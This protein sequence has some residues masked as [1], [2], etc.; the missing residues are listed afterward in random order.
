MVNSNTSPHL[1]KEALE[2]INFRTN[3]KGE[4]TWVLQVKLLNQLKGEK[5]KANLL[6]LTKGHGFLAH[7]KDLSTVTKLKRIGEV[8][9][10]EFLNKVESLLIKNGN[11]SFIPWIFIYKLCTFFNTNENHEKILDEYLKEKPA[12]KEYKEFLM[13]FKNDNNWNNYSDRS[14]NEKEEAKNVSVMYEELDYSFAPPDSSDYSFEVPSIVESESHEQNEEEELIIVKKKNEKYHFIPETEFNLG[15]KG[16][17]KSSCL[18]FEKEGKV[19][20]IYFPYSFISVN[21]KDAIK[22]AFLFSDPKL[23]GYNKALFTYDKDQ[24]LK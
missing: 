11:N 9:Q 10:P 3:L 22:N 2:K 16:F 7:L 14:R 15:N 13:K 1:I 24:K 6:D 4:T 8:C 17:G 5:P 23:D 19:E 12:Q 20:E 21:T 18:L